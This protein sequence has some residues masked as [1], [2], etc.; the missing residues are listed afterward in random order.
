MHI[1]IYRGYFQEL[2]L[3]LNIFDNPDD[4][5]IVLMNDEGQYSLWPSIVD[6]PAG[7]ATTFGPTDRQSCLNHIDQVWT[8]MRPVSLRRAMAALE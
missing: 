1:V 4:I 2:M 5:F 3:M 7:W 8:D 6:I